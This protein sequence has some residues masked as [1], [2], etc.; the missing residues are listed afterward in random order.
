MTSAMPPASVKIP[1]S[2]TSV[3]MPVDGQ[4]TSST[5]K[6]TFRMPA[7]SVQL[8]AVDPRRR[9]ANAPPISPTPA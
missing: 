5:P 8:H 4:I 7:A 6:T 2:H 1:T 9:A 3:R